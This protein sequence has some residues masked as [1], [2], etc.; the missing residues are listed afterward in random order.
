MF[1]E[2]YKEAFEDMKLSDNFKKGLATL[3]KDK[4][5]ARVPRTKLVLATV[6]GVLIVSTTFVFATNHVTKGKLFDTWFGTDETEAT[7]TETTPAPTE[8]TETTETNETTATEKEVT[9][10]PIPTATVTATPTPTQTPTPTTAPVV[11]KPTVTVKQEGDGIR[12]SWTAVTNT[13]DFQYYKIVASINCSSPRYP[14]NGYA[15]YITD[16]KTTSY[17]IENGSS[18]NGGDFCNFS[19]GTT[20]YFSVTTC[21]E[22]EKY[23]GNAVT[24]AMPGNPYVEPTCP[25]VNLSNTPVVTVT[26]GTNEGVS[27][28]WVSWTPIVDSSSGFQFYKVVAS[29]NCSSPRYPDN[30]Y[31]TYITDSSVTSYFIKT[32]SGYNGGDVGTFASGTSYYFSVT[33]CLSDSSRL[34]GNAVQVV[35]P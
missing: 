5:S 18:Y 3:M 8:T 4:K 1:D 7:V 28:V 19:G 14:D 22:D 29:P 23:V 15:T 2:K 16:A 34:A 31:A 30:G 35:M 24:A 12:I 32:G 27:G 9:P 25:P 33:T 11:T 21:Y 26:A 17:Y 20:Y 6:L 10:T 13:T